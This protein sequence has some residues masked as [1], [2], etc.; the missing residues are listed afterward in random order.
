ML[1]T[2]GGC[3]VCVCVCVCDDG[4]GAAKNRY[5]VFRRVVGYYSDDPLGGSDGEDAFDMRKPLKRDK[6]KKH[7]REHGEEFRVSPNDVW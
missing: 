1:E 3:G 5:S 2:C 7:I 4:G 6:D